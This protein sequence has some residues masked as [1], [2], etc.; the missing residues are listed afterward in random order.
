M[1]DASR[2]YVRWRPSGAE[3][4]IKVRKNSAHPYLPWS[5]SR[6][7]LQDRR[8]L[9]HD[10]ILANHSLHHCLWRNRFLLLL[11][12][13]LLYLFP[14][15]LGLQLLLLPDLH[16]RQHFFILLQYCIHLLL[17][18]FLLLLFHCQMLRSMRQSQAVV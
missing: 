1:P 16:H 4:P 2:W 11:Y 7:D 17:Y 5:P 12:L 9:P 18:M 6:S 10:G 14:L 13:L 3:P 8:I 15:L